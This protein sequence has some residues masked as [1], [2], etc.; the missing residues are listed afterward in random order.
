MA[1]DTIKISSVHTERAIINVIDFEMLLNV[2]Q[3][4]SASN[5][6]PIE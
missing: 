6:S 5:N 2:L 3:I 1:V 4:P